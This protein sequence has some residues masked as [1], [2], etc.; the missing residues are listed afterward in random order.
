MQQLAL[1]FDREHYRRCAFWKIARGGFPGRVH[2]LRARCADRKVG[3]D[4]D[5][6]RVRVKLAWFY[7]YERRLWIASCCAHA[8]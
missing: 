2:E 1:I 4:D 7:L 8:S 6:V 5:V 3:A